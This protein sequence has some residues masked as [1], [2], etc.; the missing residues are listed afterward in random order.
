MTK[1]H[2][3]PTIIDG[4]RFASKAEARRYQQLRLLERANEITGITLQPPFDIIIKGVK[5]CRYVADFQ[6][7]DKLTRKVVIEDVKGLR[8]PV[9]KIKKALMKA[10][11]GIEIQE[12]Q[13]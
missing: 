5:V 2:A 9:Y 12:V 4:I 13:A 11:H 6:Y 3:K 8:T 10:V 7:T 1:Y